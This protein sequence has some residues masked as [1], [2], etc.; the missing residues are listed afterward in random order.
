VAI[1]DVDPD[2]LAALESAFGP[3]IDSYLMGWQVWLVDARVAGEEVTLEY[4]VH[5]PAGFHQPAGLDHHDLWTEVIAQLADGAQELVLGEE[6]RALSDVF[7]LLEVYPAFGEPLSPAQVAGHVEACLGRAPRAAGAV[8]HERLGARWK[9]QRHG[10][11]LPAALRDAL[12][13]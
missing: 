4:R 13:L 7:D 1:V 3:P 8:D 5:P 6:T 9:R 2:V 12:G 10:F 11:D